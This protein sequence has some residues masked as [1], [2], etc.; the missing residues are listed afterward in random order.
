MDFHKFVEYVYNLKGMQN[1]QDFSTEFV[2]VINEII[3]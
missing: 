2:R 3:A 1:D